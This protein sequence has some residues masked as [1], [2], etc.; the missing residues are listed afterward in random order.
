MRDE[1]NAGQH[2]TCKTPDG[3]R[4]RIDPEEEKAADAAQH[5]AAAEHHR[6]E[7]KR[8]VEGRHALPRQQ[9]IV[10]AGGPRHEADGDIEQRGRNDDQLIDRRH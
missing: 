10:G 4:N 7:G 9:E 8:V 5:D 1:Q 3:D 6:G 2:N